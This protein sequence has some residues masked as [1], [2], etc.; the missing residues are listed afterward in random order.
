MNAPSP[1]RLTPSLPPFTSS[2]YT[3]RW[4][5]RV[6]GKMRVTWYVKHGSRLFELSLNEAE[7]DAVRTFFARL[8]LS[9]ISSENAEAMRYI[10]STP[11]ESHAWA[12]P[13]RRIFGVD[14]VLDQLSTA[15]I[16]PSS[17]Y[18]WLF[19]SNAV[20]V[21]IFRVLWPE[22]GHH[23]FIFP[24]TDADMRPGAISNAITQT[25]SHILTSGYLREE[26]SVELRVSPKGKDL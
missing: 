11:Q 23:M 21:S 26:W 2:S 10:N 5:F 9:Y 14:G 7:R 22:T 8:G 4:A 20:D 25:Y 17:A 3:P 19:T 13:V 18:N 15:R 12:D 6:G 24:N 16:S 1:T